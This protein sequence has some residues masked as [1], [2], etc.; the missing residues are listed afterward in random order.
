M[1]GVWNKH[2]RWGWE[3]S[4]G[5]PL[6]SLTLPHPS[7]L[8]SNCLPGSVVHCF[9]LQNFYRIY[10]NKPCRV[11]YCSI[12]TIY[13]IYYI[14]NNFFKSGSRKKRQE[15]SVMGS[16]CVQQG[17][18]ASPA[19]CHFLQGSLWPRLPESLSFLCCG[20]DSPCRPVSTQIN[21]CKGVSKLPSLW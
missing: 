15:N 6:P 16:R 8:E 2:H 12:F 18:L 3:V 13:N 5:C 7:F 11:V 4:D 21:P 10:Y 1:S 17:R 14:Y 20:D 9:C 19:S